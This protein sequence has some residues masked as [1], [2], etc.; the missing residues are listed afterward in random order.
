MRGHC[1]S[2]LAPGGVP[3]MVVNDY[4]TSLIPPRRPQVFR[5]QA[6]SYKKRGSSAAT[7]GAIEH[8]AQLQRMIDHHVRAPVPRVIV[9][10]DIAE[11]HRRRPGARIAA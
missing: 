4:T 5:E 7:K 3:T 1:E 9:R 10:V 11:S 6:R 2:E 8:L